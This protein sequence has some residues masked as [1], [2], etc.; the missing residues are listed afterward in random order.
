MAE[1]SAFDMYGYSVH[2][3][4]VIKIA[5]EVY[6]DRAFSIETGYKVEQIVWVAGS[7]GHSGDTHSNTHNVPLAVRLR[8]KGLR[9]VRQFAILS[10]PDSGMVPHRSEI[11]R[12][13][14]PLVSPYV[15]RALA[16][17]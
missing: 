14:R 8:I 4:R 2:V 5:Y 9:K 10:S 6:K 7:E 11:T 3:V 12:S 15:G 13:V 1:R 16:E 17:P